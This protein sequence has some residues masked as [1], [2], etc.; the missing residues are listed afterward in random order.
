MNKS[1]NEKTV[2]KDLWTLKFLREKKLA[3]FKEKTK[4]KKNQGAVCNL[5]VTIR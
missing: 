1:M 5:T 4:L 3:D 2:K